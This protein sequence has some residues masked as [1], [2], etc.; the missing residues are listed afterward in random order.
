[1][2][3]VELALPGVYQV[4]FEELADCRGFFGR[5]W[6]AREFGA[7]GLMTEAVQASLAHNAVNGTLRG[8]HFQAAPKREARL[9]RCVS[10]SAFM[11]VVDLRPGQ[12]SFLRHVTVVVSALNRHAIYVPA[13][14]AMGYQTLEDRTEVLYFMNEYHDPACSRGFRWN[15]PVFGIR[16]PEADRII[17]DRDRDYSDFDAGVVSGFAGY[18]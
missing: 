1:M 16:W 6:C 8:M 5:V 10:G 7:R 17:L 15:D 4:E 14:R 11:A 2:R 13:G 9:V 18:P 12:E 3:V